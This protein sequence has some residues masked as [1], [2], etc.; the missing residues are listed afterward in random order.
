MPCCA[1]LLVAGGALAAR[2][3]AFLNRRAGSK[4]K[5]TE[6]TVNWVVKLV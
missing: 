1:H 3:T 4:D 2:N 5:H 6:T